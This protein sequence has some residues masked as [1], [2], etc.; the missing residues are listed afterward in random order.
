M[1]L[2]SFIDMIFGILNTDTQPCSQECI[3]PPG[4]LQCPRATQP[5]RLTED[6]CFSI[7]KENIKPAEHAKGNQ[8]QKWN[9]PDVSGHHKPM[10]H[11]PTF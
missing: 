7:S 11:L 4:S 2:A 5:P 10:C 8:T 3:T 9:F 1:L 6:A